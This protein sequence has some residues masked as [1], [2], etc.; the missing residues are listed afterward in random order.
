MKKY[1]FG[2]I[3]VILLLIVCPLISQGQAKTSASTRKRTVAKAKKRSSSRSKPQDE[4]ASVSRRLWITFELTS[5][6]DTNIDDD[7]G[8]LNSFG[9]VPSV[10]VHFQDN[11]EKPSF[12]ADYEVALHRYTNT[13]KY[14][15]VSQSFRVSHRL[16]LS[17]R[18]L[19]RTTGE[20]SLK[21]SSEDRDVNDQYVL[22]PQ[23]QYRLNPDNRLRLFGAYRVKR[24]P[25]EDIG[26]NGVDPY[27][28]ARFDQKLKGGRGWE[29]FYRYDKNRSQDPKDR[30]VRWTYGAQFN[31][32]L[33]RE[34]H[35]QLTLDVRY[36]PRLYA[37]QVKVNDVR[38]PRRDQRW[39]FDLLYE[40]PLQ[41]G[42][43]MG[44][45]YRYETR[46]SNDPEKNF[47]SH[48]FSMTFAFKWWR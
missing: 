29:L 32:P 14:N 8:N 27:L 13:D 42:V 36:A 46:K 31:T 38:V 26:K 2:P 40:R 45:N 48:L 10:G 34:H 37:R 12:E 16:Q 17:R 39:V 3:V 22:E 4:K 33:F 20:V 44:F 5:A 47:N 1:L 41:R 43:Q 15:R 9:L 6:F 19:L 7:E 24:Y 21:G 18:W 30:Y 11:A 25:L 23:L 28:G 35:D